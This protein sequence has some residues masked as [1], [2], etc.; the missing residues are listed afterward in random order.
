[1]KEQQ[2][3]KIAGLQVEN[4]MKLQKIDLQLDGADL[5][6]AGKNAAGKTSLVEAIWAAIGGA[7]GKKQEPIRRGEKG[8]KIKLDLGDLVITRTWTEASGPMGYLSVKGSNG[9]SG[10][11][12]LLDA[13]L[14][15]VAVDPHKFMALKDAEQVTTLL[16]ICPLDIDLD[17]NLTKRRETFEERTVVNR[18]VKRIQGRLEDH[19][20]QPLP[21]YDVCSLQEATERLTAAR[22]QGETLA[23]KNNDLEE[24]R[25]AYKIA[26]QKVEKYTLAPKELAGEL[27]DELKRINDDHNE[28]LEAL[29]NETIEAKERAQENNKRLIRIA[30]NEKT[31]AQADATRLKE[32]GTTLAEEI[33]NLSKTQPIEELEKQ[34]EQAK[35]VETTLRQNE[36]HAEIAAELAEKTAETNALTTTIEALDRAKVESLKRADFPV[37]GLGIGD[38]YL[39]LGDAP[40]KQASHAQQILAT[41][42]LL[43][44]QDPAIR[45]ITITDATLLDEDSWKVVQDLSAERDMQVIAEWIANKPEHLALIVSDDEAGVF[46]RDGSVANFQMPDPEAQES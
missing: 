2:H 28:K 9:M 34:V 10:N 20:E 33:E 14:T 8:A 42:S 29:R 12:G 46:L 36:T 25:A 41:M 27:E 3:F 35:E 13:L 7:A 6:V 18:E 22:M 39:T 16:K 40:F 31:E 32:K 4:F 43:I 24:T 23:G 15:K 30:D 19:P 37:D 44:Q 1:M 11:Q 38:G 17:E 5:V 26:C 45:L 21:E